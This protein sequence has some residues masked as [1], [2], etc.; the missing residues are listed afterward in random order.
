M[1]SSTPVSEASA[2]A[3]AVSNNFRSSPVVTTPEKQS[4]ERATTGSNSRPLPRPP[5]T[6][7]PTSPTPVRHPSQ[8]RD[9]KTYPG[10]GQA[11]ERPR[12]TTQDVTL[13]A[14][15][16]PLPTSPKLSTRQS[17]ITI[18]GRETV[19]HIT[20]P[21]PQVDTSVTN[22]AYP[23]IV[24]SPTPESSSPSRN[25]KRQ[26]FIVRPPGP[27]QLSYL[28]A[29]API[30]ASLLSFLSINSFLGLTGASETLRSIFTGEQVGRWILQEW[31]FATDRERGR[32]WPNLTVWEGFRESRHPKRGA[33][34]SR[35]PLA[36]SSELQYISTSLAQPS[37]TS[38]LVTHPDSPAPAVHA[39]F[40][41]PFLSRA[42]I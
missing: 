16:N 9:S 17:G 21:A 5:K 12:P 2:Y 28:L 18:N 41:I 38:V 39:L 14:R 23:N 40:L 13:D 30:Q 19:S 24:T 7:G 3:R 42:A 35:I 10:Q 4:L 26:T 6:P 11:N 37:S 15:S 27:I 22:L 25:V 1:P 20:R 32:G 33:K 31:G 36:R 34:G 8:A 29:H